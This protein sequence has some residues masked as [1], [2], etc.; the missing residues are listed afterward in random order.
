[1]SVAVHLHNLIAVVAG[2]YGRAPDRLVAFLTDPDKVVP[3]HIQTGYA[4]R[5]IAVGSGVL[6]DVHLASG[7][8]SGR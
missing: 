7:T 8:R 3:A 4:V 2:R 5:P 6:D 1:M